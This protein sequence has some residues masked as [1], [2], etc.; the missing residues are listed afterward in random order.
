MVRFKAYRNQ[1]TETIAKHLDKAKRKGKRMSGS[2]EF[3]DVV[4]LYRFSEDKDAQDVLS[5]RS[6]QEI[7]IV[8]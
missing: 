4:H 6:G 8:L 2:T 1:P 5:S 7:V 3:L